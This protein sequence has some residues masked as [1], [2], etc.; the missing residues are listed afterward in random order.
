MTRSFRDRSR[1]GRNTEFRHDD[2]ARPREV[3]SPWLGED[4]RDYGHDGWE[5]IRPRQHPQQQEA[6]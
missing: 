1:R 3:P 2:I 5:P 6:A 4:P